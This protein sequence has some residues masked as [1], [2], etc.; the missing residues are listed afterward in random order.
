MKQRK[1]ATLKAFP[2]RVDHE[3]RLRQDRYRALLTNQPGNDPDH[4]NNAGC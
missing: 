2:P 3:E 1:N 4:H